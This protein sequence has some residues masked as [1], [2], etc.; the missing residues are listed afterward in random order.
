MSGSRSCPPRSHPLRLD[1]TQECC[2]EGRLSQS[3]A[4][5][6]PIFIH[7]IGPIIHGLLVVDLFTQAMNKRARCPNGASLLLLLQHRVENGK[8]PI[9]ELAV[10]VVWNN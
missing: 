9:L 5:V 7:F 3:V 2:S 10:V 8:Q 1:R 4:Q 6:K